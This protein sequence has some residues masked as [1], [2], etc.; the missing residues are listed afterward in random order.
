VS[1]RCRRNRHRPRTARR[2]VARPHRRASR[3]RRR[4]ASPSR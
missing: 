2:N 1:P 3:Y 4:A